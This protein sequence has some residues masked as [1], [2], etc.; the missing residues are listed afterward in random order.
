MNKKEEIGKF[1]KKIKILNH[2]LNEII[3]SNK[4]IQDGFL[5]FSENKHFIVEDFEANNYYL[6]ILKEHLIIHSQFTLI[7]LFK[8][9]SKKERSSLE[10]S[11]N[12]LEICKEESQFIENIYYNQFLEL[13]PKFNNKYKNFKEQLEA[14]RDNFYAHSDI[15]E[16]NKITYYLNFY[17]ENKDF[18]N[19]LIADITKLTTLL[20]QCFFKEFQADNLA[21]TDNNILTGKDG[22]GNYIF[23]NHE[24]NMNRILDLFNDI[25]SI[26]DIILKNSISDTEKV[27]LIDEILIKDKFTYNGRTNKTYKYLLPKNAE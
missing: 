10:K 8:I 24:T 7:N 19:E 13:S 26:Q 9:L 22:N 11:Y 6:N 1:P 20:I 3:E 5:Y 4:F 21:N 18:I 23:T 15:V 14:L 12:I 27:N 16:I 17:F 2:I 25:S